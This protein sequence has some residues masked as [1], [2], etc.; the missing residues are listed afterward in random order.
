V[1]NSM[2]E[3]KGAIP[4]LISFIFSLILSA[5][6]AP[7][8]TDI[9]ITIISAIHQ[10]FPSS[11]NILYIITLRI[12]GWFLTIDVILRIIVHFRRKEYIYA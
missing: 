3:L 2:P 8:I 6:G 10:A 5:L 12:L 9:G 1:D 4:E 7:S 11:M